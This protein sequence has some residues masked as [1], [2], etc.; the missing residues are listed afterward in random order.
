M[1]DWKEETV[2]E[3][4]DARRRI[5][6]AIESIEGE[7]TRE[8][9]HSVWRAYVSVELCVAYVKLEIDD[10]NPGRFISPRPYKVPDER[11]ALQFALRNLA[12]GEES[13]R[14]GDF[15]QALKDLR[16]ARNYLR[17]LL[18][19][20]YSRQRRARRGQT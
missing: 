17:V 14:V 12:K 4:E 6:A 18:K 2:A 1:E 10:E 15:G 9:V 16:E 19:E 11:Q 8:E 5:E 7:P 13:F 20:L 3:L